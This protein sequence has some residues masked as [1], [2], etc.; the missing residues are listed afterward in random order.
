MAKRKSIEE[1][2]FE[3]GLPA[4]KVIE[5]EVLGA[6]LRA[7]LVDFDKFRLLSGLI[8]ES[9]FT[10]EA[11]RRIFASFRRLSENGF[12]IGHGT[13]A[14]DLNDH[15]DLEAVGSFTY[16][17]NLDHA[18]EGTEYQ[19]RGYFEGHCKVLGRKT[20]QR[21]LVRVF[22]HG[23]TSCAGPGNPDDILAEFLEDAR[24]VFKEHTRTEKNTTEDVIEASGGM[25]KF[26]I[27]GGYERITF[28]PWDPLNQLLGG[29]LRPAKLYILAALTSCGKSTMAL[30]LLASTVKQ[31]RTAIFFSMEMAAPE[32]IKSLIAA[33]AG[34]DSVVIES[35]HYCDRDYRLAESA[36]QKVASWPI[37]WEEFTGTDPMKIRAKVEVARARADLGLV[38]VDYLQLISGGVK[39]FD[40]RAAELGYT[41]RCLKQLSGEFH[42]PVLALSQFNREPSKNNRRPQMSD[43]RESGSIEHEADVIIFLH[44]PDVEDRSRTTVIVEKN[45]GGRVGEFEL[46]F[47]LPFRRFKEEPV[48]RMELVGK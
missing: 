18:A 29:G 23:L 41:S 4:A 6:C 32:L 13:V 16:L 30:Q 2:L 3:D 47:E 12:P 45:R 15:Q 44:R 5:E 20:M 19:A 37:Q 43:L 35:G 24:E 25:Q 9:D 14:N 8:S 38:V 31:G 11:N 33:E 27:G 40:T 34:V 7:N 21:D 22:S 42:V 46:T 1:M 39:K 10:S 28:T 48:P 36:A 26:L 17:H